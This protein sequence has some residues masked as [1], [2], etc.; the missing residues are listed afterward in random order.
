VAKAGA[1]YGSRGQKT[2]TMRC[3]PEFERS[4]TSKTN[5]EKVTEEG[6]EWQFGWEQ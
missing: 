4:P 3:P 1:M 5:G 6:L 2:P